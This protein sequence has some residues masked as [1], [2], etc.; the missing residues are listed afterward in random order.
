MRLALYQPDIPQNTGTILRM[1][2]CLGVA[3]DIIAPTGFDMSDRSLRRAGLDYLS[4][5]ILTRYISFDA[6]EKS[7]QVDG[8]RLILLTT[9]A[10][11]PY[12]EFAFMAGDT[13]L[14]GRES[15]GVPEN[16]HDAA[17]AR[18][19]IPMKPDLRSI[20]VAMAAAIVLAEA[21]RQTGQFER[22]KAMHTGSEQ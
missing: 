6:F 12:Y 3:C 2:A 21:L 4:H 7:R 17:D 10:A 13:L 20:N 15:S 14:L 11:L 16:V 8:S 19:V 18:V 1:T 22:L 5:A 9:K